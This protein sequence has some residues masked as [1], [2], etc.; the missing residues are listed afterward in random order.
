MYDY[1]YIYILCK[2]TCLLFLHFFLI[3][4]YLHVHVIY[5]LSVISVENLQLDIIDKRFG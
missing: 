4:K 3:I 2:L 5:Y 1:I